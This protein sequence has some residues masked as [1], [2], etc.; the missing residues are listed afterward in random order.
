MQKIREFILTFSYCGKSKKAPGTVGSLASVIVWF[1][2]TMWFCN[3]EVSIFWQ[4]FIWGAT[5]LLTLIYASF[6][7][8]HYVANLAKTTG[9]S[10]KHDV[11]HQ[12]IVLDEFVGQ[13]L[14]LQLSFLFLH[15]NYFQ[16]PF[17]ITAHLIFSFI[18]FRFFDITKPSFIGYVDRN[19][20]SGF[21]V[22]FDDLLCGIIAAGIFIIG[23]ILII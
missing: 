19:F 17:L 16:K 23:Y 8:K 3:H 21:G 9:T 20:K 7:I 14:A 12:S 10:K 1:F 6:E 13:V 11:D 2:V 15:Q 22:M 4:S 18:I 5:L